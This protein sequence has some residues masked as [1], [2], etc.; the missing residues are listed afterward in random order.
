MVLLLM[1]KIL[2]H[3][4]IL[5]LYEPLRVLGLTTNHC[6]VSANGPVVCCL[7]HYP[8]ACQGTKLPMAWY[9]KNGSMSSRSSSSSS[10]WVIGN[11]LLNESFYMVRYSTH[12]STCRSLIA[13]TFLVQ[14]DT[15]FPN[16]Q[17]ALANQGFVW[18][19]FN[20][21][22]SRESNLVFGRIR[23]GFPWV[24]HSSRLYEEVC[25]TKKLVAS[26]VAPLAPH[27]W[28]SIHIW[29]NHN[30]TWIKPNFRRFPNYL[31][32]LV[33][34]DAIPQCSINSWLPT[35]MWN[36]IMRFQNTRF[37]KHQTKTIL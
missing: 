9:S 21:T 33:V 18:I 30:M 2:H 22:F 13:L 11:Y 4:G 3:L 6:E 19:C 24:D 25:D 23:H 36:F 35:L 8:Q 7:H 5:E 15:S 27:P 1:A 26:F 34:S 17:K 16:L 14:G 12:M 29:S 37:Q 10:I 32:D 20:K 28:S 31:E